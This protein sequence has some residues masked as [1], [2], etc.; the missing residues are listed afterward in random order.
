MFRKKKR[1]QPFTF[2]YSLASGES[3]LETMLRHTHPQLF[4]YMPF[5]HVLVEAERECDFYIN[6]DSNKL[7]HVPVGGGVVRSNS[8]HLWNWKIVNLHAGENK[9]YVTV[10]KE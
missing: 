9:V 8:V 5:N 1:M 2:S 7:L 3:V 6:Q 4:K 10:E